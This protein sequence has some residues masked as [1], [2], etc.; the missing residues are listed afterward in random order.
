MKKRRQGIGKFWHKVSDKSSNMKG[1]MRMKKN[2]VKGL[3]LALV[4]V[5]VV[6]LAGCSA[7]EEAPATEDAN[8]PAE[9]TTPI[10]VS[11]KPWT[12]NILLGQMLYDYLEFNGYPVKNELALG[13]TQML[14][15]AMEA[16]QI[17]AYWEYTSTLVM[18]IMKQDPLPDK[19]E[20]FKLAKDWDEA[21]KNII[22]LDYAPLNDTYGF[23][24]RPE[25]AE[26]YNLKTASDLVALVKGGE[27]IHMVMTE[28]QIQRDDGLPYIEQ[29]YDFTWPRKDISSVAWGLNL[30]TVI[31]GKADVNVGMTTDPKLVEY[32]L[33]MLP[34]DKHAFP[35][36]YA[37][38]TF[39]KE[40]I[41]AYPELPELVKQLSSVLDTD[42]IIQ[43]N[44][45]VDV[46]GKS[47]EEVSK[48]FLTEKGLIQ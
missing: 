30:L 32:K 39:R 11:S 5:L 15:P 34:D 23:Y 44:Y 43:L 1:E 47:A 41:D 28:E 33:T 38:P 45:D 2:L 13:E 31:E 12:E 8:A 3:F 22:W 36:Y 46:A 37:A 21:N 48:T 14:R 24:T 42:T 9:K 17:D 40:I 10:T 16:G 18:V 27:K 6:A 20:N 25:I 7:K 26:K 4:L 35:D 29:V 19:D